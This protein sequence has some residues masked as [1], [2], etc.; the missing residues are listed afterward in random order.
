V[1][2]NA[3]IA[4]GQGTGTIVNDDIFVIGGTLSVGTFDLTPARAEVAV[5]EHLTYRL[6]WTVPSG[7][8]HALE[9]LDL[10][11]GDN[12]AVL[13][14][15]FDE[16][17]G[18][19]SLVDPGS[20]KLGPDFAPGHPNRLETHAATLYLDGSSVQGSGPSGPSVTLTLDLSVKPPGAGQ[21]FPVE[22]RARNDAGGTQGF[23]HAATLIV[24]PKR[25]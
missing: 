8:W 2:V 20:G 3:T 21:S 18:T 5:G 10:R 22:V 25:D 12:G 6:T 9:S 16:A 1:P 7:S 15:R 14:V 13:W 11:I 17:S 4:D 19:L 24:T 23:D